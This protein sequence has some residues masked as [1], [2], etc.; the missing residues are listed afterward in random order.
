MIP[1]ATRR[2][3]RDYRPRPRYSSRRFLGDDS[4]IVQQGASVAGS[5][6]GIAGS[7][8]SIASGGAAAAT[9][10]AAAALSV[11][12]II[13]LA[14]AAVAILAQFI[15]KGCGQACIAS[16]ETEQVFEVAADIVGEAANLGMITGAEAS[17]IMQVILQ[18][19]TAQLQKLAQTDSSANGGLK[20]MTNVISP[21]ITSVETQTPTITAALNVNTVISS[22]LGRTNQAGWYASQL[23]AGEQLATQLLSELP[24]PSQSAAT[25]AAGGSLVADVENAAS[26]AGSVVG[27]S[28]TTVLIGIA[29]IVALWMFA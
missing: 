13:G 7:A 10:A 23:A 5:A 3:I 18:S 15:G 2:Q 20:N 16:A 19:G 28:G 1:N 14:A 6:A 4:Q 11:I 26:S 21:M 27:V 24:I 9:G 22:W 29:A 12:P 8:I 17:A 25:S